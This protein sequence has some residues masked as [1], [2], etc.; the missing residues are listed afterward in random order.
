MALSQADEYWAEFIK[1]TGRSEDERCA[2]D[3]DFESGGIKNDA[4]VAMILAGKKNAF[5]STFAS[6]NIDGE[7][8]PVTGELYLLFDRGR[9][10]RAVLEL[11]KVIVIPFNEVPWSLASLEGED[12]SL[13]EWRE[14]EKEYLEDEG[15]VVGFEFTPDIKLIC[16]VFS[17]VYR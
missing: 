15:A 13:E 4:Q 7:P 8:L 9:T 1:N 2:G 5:F 12:A 3:L 10:P 6:Y 16:Q 11:E 14:K 17:V